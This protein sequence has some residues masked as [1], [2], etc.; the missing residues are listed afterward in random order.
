MKNQTNLYLAPL[1]ASLKEKGNPADALQMKKYMRNQYDFFGLKG[2]LRREVCKA[3]LQENGLPDAGDLK[4]VVY[5][6]WDCP[7]REL[8]HFA[9]E[10]VEKYIKKTDDQ[11]LDLLEFM[12][13]NKSW[14]DTI[15]FIA[16]RL[17]G[18][19]F[20]Q[21]PELIKPVTEKWMESG[22]IWLQRSALLFQLKYKKDTDFELLKKYILD[23]AE[24]EE[25]FIKKAIGWSLREYSKINPET[26]ISFVKTA[27]ISN[28]SKKEA[29]KWLERRAAN[30]TNQM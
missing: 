11:I 17:V 6:L 18:P 1:L 30:L 24:S 28:F 9:V 22:N 29:M 20:K 7:E 19:F 13:T 26:V 23:L 5:N 14:W 4:D 27:P 3:F 21:Y 25:F 16:A 2:G 10:L 12:I 8:Q 15:D